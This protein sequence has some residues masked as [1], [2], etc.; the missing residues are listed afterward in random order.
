MATLNGNT[1]NRVITNI[2]NY[3]NKVIN[4]VKTKRVG[5]RIPLLKTVL[6]D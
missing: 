1:L 6:L 5:E 4:A 3:Q 2:F